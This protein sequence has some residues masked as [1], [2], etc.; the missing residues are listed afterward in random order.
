MI[1]GTVYGVMLNVA[2]GVEALGEAVNAAPYKAPP[3]APILYI[4]TAN[5]FLA[6]GGMVAV[7]PGMDELEVQ[8]TLGL[9]FG[10]TATRVTEAEALG[11]V[12][13]VVPAIDVCVP[14]ASLYRPA[15][16]HR[17]RDGFLPLGAVVPVPAG[18][19]AFDIRISI[20]GEDRGGFSTADLAR[21]IPRLIAEVTDFMTL[22]PGDVLLVGLSH[23]SPRARAGDK[24][25]ARVSG[26]GQV[27][28][29]LEAEQ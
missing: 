2:G 10:R 11:Y 23:A 18:A 20:N 29:R 22:S 12:A 19:N 13:A 16:R 26:A 5:T 21:S 25:T 17:C 3:V 28:V 6:D 24:V 14:H 4:K 9:V 8:P 15:V 7:P 27:S 1:T